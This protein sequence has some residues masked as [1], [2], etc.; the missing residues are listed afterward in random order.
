MA[1]VKLRLVFNLKTGKKDIYVDYES[2]SDSLPIEHEE[3]HRKIVDQLIE[4]DIV[5]AGEVGDLVVNRGQGTAA[6]SPREEEQPP[7]Q[8]AEGNR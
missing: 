4:K 1:E 8:Q 3:A 7:E 5:K 6:P 2:D